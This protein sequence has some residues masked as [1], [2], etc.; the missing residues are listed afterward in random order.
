[1]ESF[2]PSVISCFAA[3][4]FVFWAV[5]PTAINGSAM[6]TKTNRTKNIR[7]MVTNVSLFGAVSDTSGCSRSDQG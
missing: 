6:I 1:M 7:F 2:L 5:T 4:V 3:I